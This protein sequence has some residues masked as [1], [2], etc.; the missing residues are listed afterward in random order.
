MIAYV[1]AA[2]HD[3]DE[4]L[5]DRIDP[6]RPR[7]RDSGTNTRGQHDAAS[8]TGTLIQKIDAPADRVDEQRRRRPGRAPC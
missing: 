4:H 5:A 2:E 7:R 1:S 8:P 3:D 6:P